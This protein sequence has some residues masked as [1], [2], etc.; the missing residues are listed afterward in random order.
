MNVRRMLL[1]LATLTLSPAFN[2]Q[3]NAGTAAWTPGT[4]RLPIL[5]LDG[6]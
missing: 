6:Q 1:V 5:R 3:A 2:A 4:D